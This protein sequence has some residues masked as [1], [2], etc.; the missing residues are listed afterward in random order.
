[1]VPFDIVKLLLETVIPLFKRM[2]GGVAVSNEFNKLAHQKLL[3]SFP[4]LLDV[5]GASPF[6]PRSFLSLVCITYFRARRISVPGGFQ[7]QKP[8]TRSL[9]KGVAMAL[10]TA[11]ETSL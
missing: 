9:L 5:T 3:P 4:S 8:T 1:M 11:Q 6:P 7:E 2:E 10:K